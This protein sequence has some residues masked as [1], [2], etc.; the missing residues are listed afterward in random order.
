MRRPVLSVADGCVSFSGVRSATANVIEVDHGNGYVTRYAH[1][2]RLLAASATGPRRQQGREG[3]LDGRS[4]GAHVHFE[5]WE[6]G[7]SGGTRKFLGTSARRLDAAESL[8]R[9][10]GDHHATM[11]VAKKGRPAPI[12]CGGIGLQ[13]FQTPIRSIPDPGTRCSTACY[14]VF[15]SRNDAN[16]PSSAAGQE[17]QCARAAMQALS[18]PNAGQDPEF[19]QASE[20]RV[21]RQAAAEAFASAAR[22]ASG[23]RH[24]TLR[25]AV[26]RRHWSALGKIAEMRTGEGKTAWSR[27]CGQLNAREGKGVHGSRSTTNG[28]PRLGGGGKLYNWLGLSVSVVYPGMRTAT[29]RRLG[30]RINYAT[31][32]EIGSTYRATT[33]RLAKEDRFQRGL[34][35]R[36]STRSTRS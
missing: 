16:S 23:G 10:G 6:R 5:V 1:N 35:T 2:S 18:T 31:N 25:S 32:N 22:P 24:A 27:R 17:D 9:S 36:S 26:D 21:A 12:L 11:R 14:R 20:R 3:R 34:N 8:D 19:Q 30:R 4:T 13:V 33:W 28:A 7:C 15:G 29:S